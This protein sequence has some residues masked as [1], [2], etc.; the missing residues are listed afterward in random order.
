MI[1]LVGEGVS[2]KSIT[3][4]LSALR[5]IFKFFKR[6]GMLS[7]N[8]M[9]KVNPPRL[10]KKLPDTLRKSHIE[11]L[12]DTI[13][14]DDPFDFRNRLIIE[15]FYLT[16]IRRSELIQ[17]RDGDIDWSNQQVKV[18][19]KG[20]KE[21][22]IPL[23]AGI[24]NKIGQWQKMKTECFESE[25]TNQQLF[26]TDRGKPLY[27]KW[28]YNMVKR[29]LSSVTTQ[30]KR[31]PHVLR[32]SFATHLMDE[33]ADLNAVKELLGHANLSATQIYTHNSVEKLKAI[34]KT[35]HPKSG[36]KS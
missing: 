15:L 18:L 30:S 28:V 11:K 17:I 12:F 3:R 21:R 32:H 33:G 19:G 34:Y 27:P 5:S 2:P 36:R 4:K 13:G 16:G 22:I 7:S 14:I 1:H 9:S 29:Y 23:S 24:L 35:A 25:K 8:P 20:N 10:G 31:S 6:M 26:L